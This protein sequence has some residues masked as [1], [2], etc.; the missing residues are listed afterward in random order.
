[1]LLKIHLR[2]LTTLK[3]SNNSVWRNVFWFIKVYIL[4]NFIQY[5]IHWDKTCYKKIPLDN[6]NVTKNALFFLSQGPTH[7]SFTFNL[8]LLHEINRKVHLS[9]SVCG[10]LHFLYRLVFIKVYKLSNKRHGFYNVIIPFKIK[11]MKKPHTV[12]LTEIYF[13]ETEIFFASKEIYA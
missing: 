7:Q 5:N 9:K 6:I 8:E 10:I 1:M 12:L 11:I 2:L 4:W 13:C 3:T